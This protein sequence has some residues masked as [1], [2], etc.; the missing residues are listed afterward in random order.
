MIRIFAV[1]RHRWQRVTVGLLPLVLLGATAVHAQDTPT[2]TVPT[3][4]VG[5]IGSTEATVT[6]VPHDIAGCA[7]TQYLVRVVDNAA[8][9][10]VGDPVFV[11]ASEPLRV[12][13]HYLKPNT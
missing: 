3:V 1:L 13:F 10:Y 6:W 11:A 9:T 12:T 2:L 7:A 4:R 8:N 5:T